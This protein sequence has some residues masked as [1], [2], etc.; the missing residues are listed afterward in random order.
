MTTWKLRDIEA[1]LRASWAADTCSPDDVERAPWT[2]G[3]PS[4]GHCDVTALVVHDLLGGDLVYGE[5][6]LGGGRLGYHWW[7]RLP[8][9]AEVDLTREQFRDGETVTGARA[10]ERPA[11]RLPR[12]W[13]AYL[14]LRERVERRLGPLPA[15]PAPEPERRVEVVGGRRMSYL[16]FGGG[17]RPLL[18]LHGHFGEG[19]TFARLAREL[20]P[21]WRVLAP[22]QRGHGRSDRAADHSREGYVADA[23]ELL[24]RL[25]LEDVVVVG[26][27]LGGVNAYQ[28]AARHPRLVRALVVEDAG[29]V[30]DGDLSFCLAWPERAPT[31]RALVEALGDSA[32]H[33]ADA[34]REH[35]DGWGLAFRPGDMVASQRQLNGDHWP[36]WLAG[37]CPAL[38]VRGTSSNVLDAAHARE[39]AA[40]RPGTRLVHLPAGHAVHAVHATVPGPFAAVV[41]EFLAALP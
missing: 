20:G 16:D 11:G 1:A 15:P 7:N 30:V 5:V 28:L 19:R 4:R 34:V 38:L 9:G 27:S 31:R 13:D 12:R 6:R 24:D 18:A 29:A 36:D 33:L 21:G 23:A 37:D 14:R 10:V 35:P 39:M 26:H 32:R 22:D 3:N 40:R 25:G 41:R 2:G 8:S 17:G